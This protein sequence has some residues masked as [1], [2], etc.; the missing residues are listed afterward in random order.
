MRGPLSFQR[1]FTPGNN[2]IVIALDS[3]R[4]LINGPSAAVASGSSYLAPGPNRGRWAG[5]VVRYTVKCTTQNVTATENILTG[6]AGTSADWE[7]QGATGTQ[8]VTAGT[9]LVREWKPEAGDFLLLITA[10]ATGP[11]SCIVKVELD[12]SNNFGG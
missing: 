12:W 9:T 4:G 8:T 3:T 1:T 10:G 5:A 2:E 11:G 7:V 6:N